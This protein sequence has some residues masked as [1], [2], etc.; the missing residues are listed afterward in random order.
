MEPIDWGQAW[1][2][3]GGGLLTTFTIMSLL[4]LFTHVMGKF[5]VAA[6]KRKAAQRSAGEA[7][8]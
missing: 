6:E 3:V 5:F 2:I 1:S 7:A 8:K 4:A